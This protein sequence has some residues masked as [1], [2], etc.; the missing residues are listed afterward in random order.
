M[1]SGRGWRWALRA[2]LCCAALL[3]PCA[4]ARAMDA[5]TV[6]AW[7]EQFAGS[8]P[9][10]ALLGDPAQTVNPARDG[11]MLLEYAFGTV[12]TDGTSSPS[13]EEILEI[14]IRTDQVADCRGVRVGMASGAALEGAAPGES[15]TRLYVLGTQESGYG[16]S[17]AYMG[18]DGVYGVEYI[19]YDGS[20]AQMTEYTL[21]YVLDGGAIKAIRVKAADATLAQAQEG[22]RTAEEIAE[23]Q[24]GEVLVPA[25][26]QSVFGEADLQAMGGRALGVPVSELVRRMG[27]PSDVQ[28]LPQGGGRMLLYD[29]A[30]ARLA[31]DEATGEE[32][33]RGL[34]VS[35]AAIE[36]PRGLAVGLS[37]QEAASL[38]CC[39][40]DVYSRGGTLY[41]AG[42]AAGEAP[43]G[44]LTAQGGTLTLRYACQ[45]Q[46]GEVA[47]LEA[48]IEDG[49]VAYWSLLY[50]DDAEGGA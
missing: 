14:D 6:R 27:E 9:G 12:L 37:V 20:D 22:L 30:V 39:E 28:T 23:R 19:T 1:K 13:A 26:G 4:C 25:N 49:E 43:Y 31:L 47:L 34:S 21:T 50:Q 45:T 16:W 15:D 3:C 48:G 38:F 18:E 29:G 24:Q 7:M 44:E 42:E 40:A 2:A 5:Q 11:Q 8:L 35:S 46:S 10:F 33:V 32:L 41:L 36:G 17:W